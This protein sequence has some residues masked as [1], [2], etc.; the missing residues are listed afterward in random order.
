MDIFTFI[1]DDLPNENTFDID[2]P[3][4]LLQSISTQNMFFFSNLRRKIGVVELQLIR[5]KT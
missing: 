4:L 5:V 3:S 2:H 1:N